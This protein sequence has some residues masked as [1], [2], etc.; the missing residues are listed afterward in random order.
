M[1]RQHDNTG[2]GKLVIIEDQRLDLTKRLYLPKLLIRDLLI[3]KIN[4]KRIRIDSHIANSDVIRNR[5]RIM[6][7]LH[8]FTFQLLDRMLKFR[9]CIRKLFRLKEQVCIRLALFLGF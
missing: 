3:R 8:Q 5:L 1:V 2:I 6:I 7:W 9:I 4:L